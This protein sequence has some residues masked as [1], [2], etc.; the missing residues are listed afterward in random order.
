[1]VI[2]PNRVKIMIIID[3]EIGTADDTKNSE[4]DNKNPHENNNDSEKSKKKF[5]NNFFG[6]GDTVKWYD[7]YQKVACG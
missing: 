2:R 3:E 7:H 6:K 1:M 4:N 5:H